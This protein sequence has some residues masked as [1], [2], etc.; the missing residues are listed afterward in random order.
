MVQEKQKKTVIFDE[1]HQSRFLIF[2]EFSQNLNCFNEDIDKKYRWRMS[3]QTRI[4]AISILSN[5]V[6]I[7]YEKAIKEKEE[8]EKRGSG[9]GLESTLLL[10]KF[11]T[12]L[13]AVY[14]LCDN[15]AFIGRRLH[16]GIAQSFNEQRKKVGKYRDQYPKYSEYFSLFDYVDWY[17]QLH[18]MRSESTHYL[19]GFVYYSKS[20]M[21]ILYKNM[22]HLDDPNEKIDIENILEYVSELVNGIN[23]FLDQYGNYHLKQFITDEHT[24]FSACLI[25]HPE[26]K[27][28]LVGGRVIKKSEYLKKQPGKCIDNFECPNRGYC[29]AYQK[30][31]ES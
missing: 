11:E 8:I 18:K 17:E 27:G 12:L 23:I 13:N 28:F 30:K 1:Y 3:F 10:I 31:V 14:S 4:S 2:L 21:G 22:E 20:G 19:P 6:K 24:T 5:D 16:P 9:S 26:G 7:Q 25:P 29:S 15:L